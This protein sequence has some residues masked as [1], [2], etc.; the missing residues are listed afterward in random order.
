MCGA[1]FQST[2][3]QET[4]TTTETTVLQTKTS[5]NTPNT[6]FSIH[7]NLTTSNSGYETVVT[8]TDGMLLII[9]VRLDILFV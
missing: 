5:T 3:S 6:T 1:A 4:E 7:N 8:S 9:F 2:T